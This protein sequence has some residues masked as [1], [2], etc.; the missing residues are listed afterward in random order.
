MEL[1][2]MPWDCLSNRTICPRTYFFLTFEL[3]PKIRLAILNSWN[4]E[5]V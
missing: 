4:S 3:N 2:A 5:K 1:E